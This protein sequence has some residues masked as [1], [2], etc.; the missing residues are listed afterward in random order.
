MKDK[1]ISKKLQV[2]LNQHLRRFENY[3]TRPVYKFIYQMVFGI[4]KSG[5][6]KVSRIAKSLNEVISLKKTEERLSR[7]LGKDVLHREIQQSHILLNSHTLKSCKFHI[8]DLTDIQK[9]YALKMEGLGRVRDGD[10]G[11][12]GNGYYLCNITSIDDSGELIFPSYSELYSLDEE[13]TSENKKILDAIMTVS[14]ASREDSIFVLDRGCDRIEIMKV[15]L[16]E[17]KYF[18]IRQQWNRDLY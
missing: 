17:K 18:I 4:I 3:F 2:K 6:L 7:N 9:R 13:N 14:T 5:E 12:I 8:V 1:E 10:K 15:L 16:K 11:I